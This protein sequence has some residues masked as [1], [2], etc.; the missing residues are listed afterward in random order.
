[1]MISASKKFLY[2]CLRTWAKHDDWTP[3]LGMDIARTHR[4]LNACMGLAGECGEIVEPIKKC[5]YHGKP[6]DREK[7]KLEFGDV[8][9]YVHV[10]AHELDIDLEECMNLVLA[11]LEKR[12]PQQ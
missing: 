8:L 2:S 1:M 7:L 11:K 5:I 6:L 4:I 12:Y 9:F 10:L 3:P